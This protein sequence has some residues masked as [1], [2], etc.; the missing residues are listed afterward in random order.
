[1]GTRWYRERREKSDPI[2][3]SG[4]LDK[5][6][7]AQAQLEVH[8]LIP[9]NPHRPQISQEPLL[10]SLPSCPDANISLN[11]TLQLPSDSLS[12]SELPYA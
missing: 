5:L 4:T 8:I 3:G 7:E 9:E 1:M 10:F 12:D 2:K 6:P 11:K